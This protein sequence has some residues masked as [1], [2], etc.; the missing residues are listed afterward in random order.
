MR[1]YL[2]ICI[3]LLA[4][5]GIACPPPAP[6]VDP[7]K[8]DQ[9][10][11]ERPLPPGDDVAVL[12]PRIEGAL[13]KIHANELS[14]SDG[15]WTVFHGILGMGPDKTMLTDAKT[16]KQV[17]AIDYICDGGE[18]PGLKF[19]PTDTGLDVYTSGFKDELQFSAQGH[20]DQFIAEM[21]Q[22][23]MK[24]DRPFRVGKFDYT[25]NDFIN[26]STKRASVTK[27]QELSWAII[28]ISQFPPQNNEWTNNFGET[29][30]LDQVVRYEVDASINE[31]ACGGT[32]RLFGLTWAYHLHLK[33]GGAK[34]GVWLDVAAK[35]E[36]YKS[37]AGQFQ[38]RDGTFST[39][40][41]K[42]PGNDRDY[43]KRVGSTGHILEWLALAMTDQELRSPW[44][45]NAV[46]ALVLMI[47][48]PPQRGADGGAL[49]HAAH[50][51]QIYYDRV[52]GTPAEYLPL[53]R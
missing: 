37:L 43:T 29:L 45:Q 48:D 17:K 2:G 25:F 3:A 51:L 19:I 13:E 39:D 8:K 26:H 9:G 33:K 31:A 24:R 22:W 23:G 28:I 11:V 50:G 34:D 42:G 20:Q 30:R 46:N 47:L 52:F 15:F 5:I 27:N 1:R 4:L 7:P 32:H 12:K 6:P 41:F 14:S 35:I 38:N 36:Q 21:T 40:Y 49:Y 16:G 44:M 18:L 53:I 10:I